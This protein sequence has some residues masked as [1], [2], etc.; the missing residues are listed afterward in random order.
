MR[1]W[2]WEWVGLHNRVKWK[3]FHPCTRLSSLL[4]ETTYLCS[5]LSSFVPV[6]P[7]WPQELI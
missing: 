4:C 1:G 5:S 2:V 6:F 7:F 3:S